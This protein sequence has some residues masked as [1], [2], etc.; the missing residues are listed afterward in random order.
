MEIYIFSWSQV[1]ITGPR[2]HLA[3]S[4]RSRVQERGHVIYV[5][6]CVPPGWI[7]NVVGSLVVVLAVGGASDFR[8]WVCGW[9][10]WH[11]SF[12]PR[13]L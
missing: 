6:R 10:R 3:S 11:A 2:H 1:R 8:P 4:L 5:H 13:A 12:A 7:Y 9:G